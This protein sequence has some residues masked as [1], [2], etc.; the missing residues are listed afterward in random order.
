VTGLKL[1]YCSNG[2]VTE[3][4]SGFESMMLFSLARFDAITAVFLPTDV[5]Y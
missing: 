5:K 3:F 2:K 4:K 1:N